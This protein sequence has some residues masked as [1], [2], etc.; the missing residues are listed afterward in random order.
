MSK[1]QWGIIGTGTIASKFAIALNSVD[2]T[3][4]MAVAS[5]NYGRAREFAE[6]YH[7]QK[8]YG[9]YEELAADPE[10][11]VVYIAT[12]HTKHMENASLCIKNH[13]AVL[14]EK[15]FALNARDSEVLINQAKEQGVFL[16]EAMWTKFLPVTK[17]VKEWIK[18]G[19][20]GKVLNLKVT[21]GFHSEFSPAGRLYNPQ[22][23]GGALLDVGIYPVTY[24]TYLLD[25]LPDEIISTAVIG[26]SHVDEQNAM[27]FRYHDGILAELSSSIAAETG[28]DAVIVGENGSIHI[29][30]F[31]MSE[32]AGLYDRN[33]NLADTIY[34]PHKTNGY[35]YEAMEVNRCLAEGRLESETLPLKDTLDIMK[36]LDKIRGQWGLV[37]PQEQ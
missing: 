5:R 25:K 36:L 33:F 13:K 20:I 18:E 2:N 16:M 32:R 26:K 11:D 29:E 23:G 3:S 7:I 30:K 24:V 27:I 17:K 9:S 37:Y 28:S 14:C 6:K 35:E 8:A 21:F 19:R 4:L 15:P 1:I 12:P 31:F 34:E 22:L 10:I